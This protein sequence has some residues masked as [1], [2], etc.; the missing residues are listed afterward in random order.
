[1]QERIQKIM[2]AAG[3]ASRRKCEELIAEGRVSVNGKTAKLGEKADIDKD[4]IRVDGERLKKPEAKKYYAVNKPRGFVSTVTDPF[5][6]RAVIQLVPSNERL[7]PV[8]RL[9]MDAEG[10]IIV[11]NDGRL[12]NILMHPRYEAPKTYSVTLARN[13][14]QKDL[15]RLKKGVMFGW[16]RIVPEKVSVHTPSHVEITLHEGR[17]HI[18]KIMFKK[19]GY[20]VA[21]LKRTK[22]ANILLGALPSGACRELTKA[23]LAGLQRLVSEKQ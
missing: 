8:G 5:G 9:D 7:Y 15:R 1:M 13:I 11:T 6:R 17:K 22:M 10:L 4:D 12:A 14:E 21:R 18:V 2:A 16:R 19:L 3:I 20:T 23:E